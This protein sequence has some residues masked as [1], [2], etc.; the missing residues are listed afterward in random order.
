MRWP[1]DVANYFVRYSDFTKTPLQVQKLTYIA[2]GYMLG[3]HHTPL[4]NEEPEAR[5]QGPVFPS[6]RKEFKKW[7]SGVIGMIRYNYDTFTPIEQDILDNMYAHYGRFD[8]YFLSDITQDNS[9]KPTPWRQCYVQGAQH[10]RIP[11]EITQ[12]YYANLYKEVK[13]NY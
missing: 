8:G 9:E 10:I 7:K 5:D 1:L 11:N 2:H 12:K 4:V 6:I 3:I 13:Y